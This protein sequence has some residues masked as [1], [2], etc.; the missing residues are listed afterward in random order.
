[1]R[2][3]RLLFAAARTVSTTCV[4]TIPLTAG[5]TAYD[6]GTS[7]HRSPVAVPYVAD[8]Y[9]RASFR[10]HASPATFVVPVKLLLCD[11]HPSAPEKFHTTSA[12]PSSTVPPPPDDPPPPVPGPNFS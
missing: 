6:P 5:V 7:S 10:L 1:M 4:A 12:L 11:A 3:L 9:T 8:G 2:P